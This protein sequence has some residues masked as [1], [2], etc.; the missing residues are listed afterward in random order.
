MGVPDIDP[1]VPQERWARHWEQTGAVRSRIFETRHKTRDGRIIPVEVSANHFDYDGR[2]YDL[3]LVRDI[4]DRKRAEEEIRKLNQELEQRVAQRTAALE[5]A[6][7]EL[8]SFSYSVSHDL[9]APLRTITGFSHILQEEHKDELDAEGQRFLELVNQGAVQMAR[10]IDDILAFSRMARTRMGTELVNMTALAQE[11]FSELQLGVPGRTIRLVLAPLPEAECDRMMIRQ[12][13]S[14]LL[15]NAIKYTARREEAVIEVSGAM[16]G[17]ELVYC[18]KDNGAGF[19]MRY[20]GKLFGVFQRLHSSEQFE[21]TG[22]G[23]AIVRRIVQRHGGRVW[24]E[25]QVDQ[26]AT[27]H[28][29]LPSSQR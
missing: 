23:L 13:W 15:A 14:N 4:T 12:V 10:L 21:G 11:V 26:G 6:K 27:F 17:S 18:V 19:D 5:Q 16:Q 24:A 28:F 7:E 8:E 22:I 3:A 2:S 20:A 9:R 25:G 1:G 29:A